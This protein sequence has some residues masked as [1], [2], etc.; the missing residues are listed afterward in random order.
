MQ[1]HGKGFFFFSFLFFFFFLCNLDYIAFLDLSGNRDLMRF[2]L[3]KALRFFL[4]VGWRGRILT[5]LFYAVKKLYG[6]GDMYNR[7]NCFSSLDSKQNRVIV[8][9]RLIKSIISYIYIYI[10]LIITT[11]D[12]H[13]TFILIHKII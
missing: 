7:V 3:D 6:R 11:S 13:Q 2:P 5:V 8:S 1:I 12:L 4:H 9:S 10:S